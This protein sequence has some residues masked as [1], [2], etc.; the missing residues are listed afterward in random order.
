MRSSKRFQNSKA[1]NLGQHKIELFCAKV[2]R[3]GAV[4]WRSLEFVSGFDRRISDFLA[5]VMPRRFEAK[6]RSEVFLPR[7]RLHGKLHGGT[8]PRI[9]TR[10]PCKTKDELLV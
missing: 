5:T 4:G 1:Q 9:E 7:K 3:L 2:F 6:R 8:C 10:S